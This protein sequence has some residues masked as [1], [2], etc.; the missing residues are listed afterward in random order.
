MKLNFISL[1]W[2]LNHTSSLK[3]EYKVLLYRSI[4]QSIWT[5]GIQLCVNAS[6]SN[7]DLTQRQQSKI[8]RSIV[9]ASWY[10]SNV[11]IHKDLNIPSV[12]DALNT[13]T[14][15]YMHKLQN[16]PNEK[17]KQLLVTNS[18]SR[19]RRRDR[20]TLNWMRSIT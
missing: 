11:N 5:Y 7:V 19:L 18:I 17:A 15:N 1:H 2:L 13:H 6:S 10:I 4:I 8:L 20:F 3:L 16:H 12:K 14:I 9:G